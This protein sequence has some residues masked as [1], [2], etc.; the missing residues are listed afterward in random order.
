MLGNLGKKFKKGND[1]FARMSEIKGKSVRILWKDLNYG[2]CLKNYLFIIIIL[3]TIFHGL[4]FQY[5]FKKKD[6][7]C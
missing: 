3:P 5:N 4:I 6:E 2:L 1:L 7:K